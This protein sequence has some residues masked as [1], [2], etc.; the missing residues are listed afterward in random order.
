MS[1]DLTDVT[2]PMPEGSS[3]AATSAD[4]GQ[5]KELA[6]KL[7]QIPLFSGLQLQQPNFQPADVY[8]MAGSIMQG[9]VPLPSTLATN[10][11]QVE[12]PPQGETEEAREILKEFKEEVR[13]RTPRHIKE[14]AAQILL[15]DA[16]SLLGQLPQPKDDDDGKESH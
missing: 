3:E 2:S 15:E 1:F 12:E 11:M 4:E 8:H 13:D 9:K 6:C 10:A 7:L 16:D 5:L 14:M